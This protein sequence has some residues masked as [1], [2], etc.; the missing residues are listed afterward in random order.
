M[1]DNKKMPAKAG[2]Y[3]ADTN[4]Q[5]KY[6]SK[7]IL[8]SILYEGKKDREELSRRMSLHDREVRE[9]IKELREEGYPICSSSACSGYWIGTPKE[10]E[11]TIAEYRARGNKCFKTAM[12]MERLMQEQGQMEVK[13]VTE[14]K[15][16][17]L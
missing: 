5:D 13:Y 14:Y 3:K 6:T 7:A 15:A 11:R 10:A 2:T 9:L 17:K 16:V 12:M 1:L 4:L 8:L